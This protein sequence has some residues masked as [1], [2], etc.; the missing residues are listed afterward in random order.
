MVKALWCGIG[1]IQKAIRADTK[2]IFKNEGWLKSGANDVA[3]SYPYFMVIV[4]DDGIF[5]SKGSGVGNIESP[6]KES[7]FVCG[8][9]RKKYRTLL[10]A[11][12]ALYVYKKY[13]EAI[14]PYGLK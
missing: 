2:A 8:P 4:W 7:F 10:D 14:W 13:N 1:N 9:S 5:G 11:E 3:V 12:K 6:D